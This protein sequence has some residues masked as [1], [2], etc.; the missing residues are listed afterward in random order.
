MAPV[1]DTHE[2]TSSF[3]LASAIVL[4]LRE[5]T[6]RPVAEQVR[7]KA[8]LEALVGEVI[9]PLPATG[10]I[11]LEV[12]DGAAIVVLGSPKEALDIAE[13]SQAGAADL[14]LCIGVNYGPVTPVADDFR[15]Q[16]LM[17][18]GL[19]TAMTLSQATTP[20]R[21]LAS[22]SF[23][24]ALEA[25]APGRAEELKHT[26]MF[27]DSSLRTHEI[28]TLDPRA[29]RAHQRRRIAFGLLAVI[30]ILAAGFGARTMRSV[31][32]ST[33]ASRATAPA[34]LSAPKPPPPPLAPA[35]IEFA[36]KPKGDVY[37]DGVRKGTTPPLARLE[38]SPGSHTIKV[39]YGKFAPVYVE[40]NLESSE[41][42]IVKHAF[43]RK[44]RPSAARRLMN[45]LR[46][47]LGF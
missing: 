46:R 27:T 15:G 20:G 40:V 22:R 13:R 43:V 2:I 42:V 12:P 26:G 21:F 28:Y 5:Y 25:S 39:V 37:I 10:R 9:R 18:D 32:V 11:V 7:L 45:D 38:V 31:A 14:P 33:P 1:T 23:H 19:V 16:G 44:K 34:P 4:K 47:Q 29:A 24:E 36:I 3:A 30:A 35:V 17:G 41:V 6:R 8:R